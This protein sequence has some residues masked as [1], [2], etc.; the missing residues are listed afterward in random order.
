METERTRIHQ[1]CPR[2][3]D[4]LPFRL[5]PQNWTQAA[6]IRLKI[7]NLYS[8]LPLEVR[9]QILK[10]VLTGLKR[11]PSFAVP[12]LCFL[13]EPRKRL[14]HELI[15]GRTNLRYTALVHEDLHKILQEAKT[16]LSLLVSDQVDKLVAFKKESG[17]GS[18]QFRRQLRNSREVEYGIGEMERLCDLKCLLQ[19]WFDEHWARWPKLV[20]D[21][22]VKY[23]RETEIFFV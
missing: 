8:R 20:R 21:A 13:P 9:L 14:I 17:P 4:N 11:S 12:G 23:R 1:L 6:R 3:E 16:R 18:I 7:S 5:S 2:V 15:Q 10:H 22:K 19:M